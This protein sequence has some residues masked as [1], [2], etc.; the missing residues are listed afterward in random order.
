M[1]SRRFLLALLF[2]MI[3][4]SASCI[5]ESRTVSRGDIL[6]LR[7]SKTPYEGC[8][9]RF[10]PD[11]RKRSE[12]FY[13]KGKPT[14]EGRKW[15]ENGQKE[16][17]TI[18]KSGKLYIKRL[19]N[20]EGYLYAFERYRDGK[21]LRPVQMEY[22]KALK[23]C[24]KARFGGHRDWKLPSVRELY[25]LPFSETTKEMTFVASNPPKKGK[26]EKEVSY[27]H[28][29]SDPHSG[30]WDS[31][32]LPIGTTFNV[33]CVR[34]VDPRQFRL[35]MGIEGIPE[36]TSDAVHRTGRSTPPEPVQAAQKTP[37]PK[38]KPVSVK[39]NGVEKGLRPGYYITVYTFTH[40]PPE[41]TLLENILQNGY[42]YKYSEISKNGKK[43]TRVLVGPF[44]SK[45]KAAKE[46]TRVHKMIEPGAY[47][48]DN[49][50]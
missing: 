20:R 2:P 5:E 48:I 29:G 15:Y 6:Y 37:R 43:M 44:P 23:A 18:Y 11:G 40:Y 49:R 13:R 36:L 9:V 10:Y 27:V 33:I 47:I 50:Y 1:F 19:W 28:F 22:K 41:K 21:L 34:A 4:L 46:L 26:K 42:R 24:K 31:D 25:R 3:L 38:K 16:S 32:D 7:K 12:L 45:K 17:E 39:K 35:V 30:R 14:G 8:I